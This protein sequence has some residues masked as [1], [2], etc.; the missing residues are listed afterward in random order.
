MNGM[1]RDDLDESGEQKQVLM[2]LFG[3]RKS[4]LDTVRVDNRATIFQLLE[5]T[6][7]SAVKEVFMPFN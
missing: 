1:S 5:I 7:Y 2:G 4:Q 6:S 3:S